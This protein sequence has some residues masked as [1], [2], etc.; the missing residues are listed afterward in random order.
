MKDAISK[1]MLNA[2]SRFPC[3]RVLNVTEGLSIALHALNVIVAEGSCVSAPRISS[4]TGFSANHLSKIMRKLVESDIVSAAK[5]AGGGFFLT[6]KQSKKRL[7]CVYDAVE[8]KLDLNSCLY[9]NPLC[10]CKNCIFGPMIKRFNEEFKNYLNTTQIK[11]L[12]T[13]IK[14]VNQ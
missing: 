2:N 12:R 11:Q 3:T 7:A 8:G 4:L 1:T 10:D 5:G 14:K 6:D 9:R 13:K